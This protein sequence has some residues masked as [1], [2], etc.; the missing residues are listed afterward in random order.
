MERKEA[1]RLA[2]NIAKEYAKNGVS[3][4]LIDSLKNLRTYFIE[5]KDPS[6]T[7]LLRLTYEYLENNDTFDITLEDYEDEEL[8]SF[9]YLMQLIT[10]YDNPYNREELMEYKEKLQEILQ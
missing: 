9:E 3:E 4:K 5:I 7:K 6:I 10:A 1:E 2:D 8:S